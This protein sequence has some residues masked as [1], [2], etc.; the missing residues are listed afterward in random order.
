MPQ[1]QAQ[2]L[3]RSASALY[4]LF[5]GLF[6]V[7]ASDLELYRPLVRFLGAAFARVGL[8]FLWVDLAAGMPWWWTACEGP[9]SVV[10]GAVLFWLRAAG[11][12]EREARKSGHF[13]HFVRTL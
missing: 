3:A 8:V 7:L 12:N 5:G 4:A 2:Y 10:V 9:G 6:L 13:R 1:L 11:K